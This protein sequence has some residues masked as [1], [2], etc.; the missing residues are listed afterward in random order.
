MK[1]CKKKMKQT[2]RA[3]KMQTEYK[4]TTRH[5]KRDDIHMKYWEK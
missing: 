3:M 2:P 5:A 1:F 4:G